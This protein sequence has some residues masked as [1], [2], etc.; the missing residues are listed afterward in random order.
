MHIGQ[1]GIGNSASP[2]AEAHRLLGDMRGARFIIVLT[3][4]VWS[5]QQVAID[6]AKACHHSEIEV[7]AI[8]F[9]GADEAFLRAIATT[10]KGSFFAKS[11][12][13][14]A[15]FGT[16][17]QELTETGGAAKNKGS[18]RFF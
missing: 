10:E 11:G 6:Q 12:E 17:A 2:F 15:T 5:Y 13:L 14:V 18:L 8:G 3:D 1:V 7:I 4:G 16:I 9:G